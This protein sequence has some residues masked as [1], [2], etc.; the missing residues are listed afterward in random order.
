MPAYYFH[1][2]DGYDLILDRA[3]RR[4][5]SRR[6]AEI[7]AYTV[8]GRVM[9]AARDGVDWSRWLVTVQ[10]DTGSLVAVVPFPAGQ[11]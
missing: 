4:M 6:N 7:V 3:G 1:C 9:R 10:D 2:T 11:A 5:R 8:A